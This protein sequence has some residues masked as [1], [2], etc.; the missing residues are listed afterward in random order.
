FSGFQGLMPWS[1]SLRNA[2]IRL[3]TEAAFVGLRAA[4]RS[5]SLRAVFV[6]KVPSVGI[7]IVCDLPHSGLDAVG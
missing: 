1:A 3:Q 7:L 2:T 6:S 4:R 5:R